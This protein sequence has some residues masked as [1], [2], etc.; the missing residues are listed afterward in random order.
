MNVSRGKL[1]VRQITKIYDQFRIACMHPFII[2][3]DLI[4]ETKIF[5]GKL[6]KIQFVFYYFQVS[7]SQ[8]LQCQSSA[9]VMVLLMDVVNL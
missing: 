3:D 8:T 2:S 6:Y 1:V 4:P 9:Y 5:Y 7:P